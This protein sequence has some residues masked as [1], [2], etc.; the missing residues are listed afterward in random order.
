MHIDLA[1]VAAEPHPSPQGLN[2]YA[3]LKRRI[4]A[5][6]LLKRQPGYYAV[7]FAI[8][9]GLLAVG[10]FALI[11]GGSNPWL[12][13]AE[14][15]FLAFVVVQIGLLAHDLAHQQIVGEIGRAHV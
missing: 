8:T 3:E 4:V 10:V 14:A 1:A 13:L 11:A 7:K 15:A 9:G 12:R 2:D 5:L 6:G